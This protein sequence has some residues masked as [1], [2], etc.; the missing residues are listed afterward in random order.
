MDGIWRCAALQALE[1][2][3]PE[4]RQ[5]LGAALA[6]WNPADTSALILLTPW[7]RVWEV[8]EHAMHAH[9]MCT[10]TQMQNGTR[11]TRNACYA[12]ACEPM[13]GCGIMSSAEG[14]AAL[15]QG[16]ACSRDGRLTPPV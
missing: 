13:D 10:H 16:W 9:H 15:L 11:C 1:S 7:H 2:L 3:Y 5:K 14:S 6:A 8:R 4:I 12:T